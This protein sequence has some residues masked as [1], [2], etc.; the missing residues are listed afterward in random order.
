MIR[1]GEERERKRKKGRDVVVTRLFVFH[2][3]RPVSL[4][5]ARL[6]ARCEVKR[7]EV[8][9]IFNLNSELLLAHTSELTRST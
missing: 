2:S 7:R 8:K 1:G 6:G 3:L 4:R 5:S 9:I